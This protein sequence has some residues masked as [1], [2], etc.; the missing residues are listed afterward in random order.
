M[1]R[2][3]VLPQKKRG[4]AP[5]GKGTLI[6]VRLQP[7]ILETIDAWIA[8]QPAPRPTRPEAM[9]SL[10][11]EALATTPKTFPEM[12]EAFFEEDPNRIDAWSNE[13]GTSPQAAAASFL[14][15]DTDNPSSYAFRMLEIL[16][17][18]AGPAAARLRA[19]LTPIAVQPKPKR[20]RRR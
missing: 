13:P 12:L 9:R 6:G 17:G 20:R 3:T 18:E 16:A 19:A 2:Q 11:A 7:D 4:P 1:K 14:E 5:T 10:A 8:K 15:D